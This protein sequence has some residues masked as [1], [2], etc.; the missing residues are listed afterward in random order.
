MM[1][2]LPIKVE[3]VAEGLSLIQGPCGN[4]AVLQGPEGLTVI[5][6]GVPARGRDLFWGAKKAGGKPVSML[7]N[8]HWHFDHAGGNEAFG[9]GGAVIMA[10]SATRKRL[11][12]E[13][14]TEIFKLTTPPSPDV[15]LPKWSFSG[16]ASHHVGDATI[17]LT[18]VP[19]GFYPNIDASSE[20]G[21]GAVDVILKMAG[22]KTKIIPGH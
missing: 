20:G 4:I 16:V 3:Q 18:S 5:D 10:T 22:S 6:P 9:K 1:N 12:N 15:A 14:D 21:I 8:T 13:Q 17:E 19:I 11:A 7:I 2:N